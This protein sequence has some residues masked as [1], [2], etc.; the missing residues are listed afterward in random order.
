MRLNGSKKEGNRLSRRCA[1]LEV[2]TMYVRDAFTREQER[3]GWCENKKRE[4]E[5][6]AG[7][8]WVER[9]SLEERRG[10]MKWMCRS[11]DSVNARP[12]KVGLKVYLNF[13]ILLLS[14]V[15]S[16]RERKDTGNFPRHSHSIHSSTIRELRPLSRRV[17]NDGHSWSSNNRSLGLYQAEE[18]WDNSG[19]GES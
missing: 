19:S 5:C 13:T 2:S 1:Y 8:W 11:C 4:Q 15:K 17:D 18:W 10:R 7:G 12:G 9:K 6:C 3:L 14:S 16:D